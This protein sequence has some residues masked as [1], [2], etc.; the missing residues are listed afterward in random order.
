MDKKYEMKREAENLYTTAMVLKGRGDLQG[1]KPYAVVSA[2][3]YKKLN[4]QTLEDAAPTRMRV[5]GIELPDIMHE[6][7]VKQRFGIE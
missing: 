1:A 2:R 5:Q 4:I 6:D 7:V 3:L